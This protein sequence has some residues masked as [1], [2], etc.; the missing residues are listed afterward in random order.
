MPPAGKQHNIVEVISGQNAKIS[1]LFYLLDPLMPFNCASE[2][3]STSGAISPH[4]IKKRMM[5]FW[6]GAFFCWALNN[7]NTLEWWR[8]INSI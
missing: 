8:I 6:S 3:S 1:A 7:E 4:F 5:A 2:S